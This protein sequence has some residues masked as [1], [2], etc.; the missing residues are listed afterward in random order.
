VAP[1]KV[2][3]LGAGFIADIHMESYSRFVPDAQVTA[4]YSRT[5]ERA[6]H[7]A[8]QWKIPQVFTDLDRLFAEADCEVVD[9]CL[10][11]FLHHKATLGAAYSGRHVDEMIAVCREHNRKLMY[12]EELCFA[13]KYERIR[14][15]AKEGAVGDIYMLKQLEKHSGPHSDWFWDVNQSGGGVLMDMGC[16]AFGWFRWMLNN[17]PAKSVW[18]TMDTVRHKARTKGEDNTV[19]VVEFE[20]GVIG[21]AEDGWAKPGGMD[22]RIEVYGTK[23]VSFADLFRGN[24]SSTYSEEGYGYA[25]EKAGSTTGWTY[26]IFEEAFNQGYPHELHHFIQC[27]RENKTPLVTGED[28]RAVLEMIYAAYAS[29]KSGAKVA[30]PFHPKVARPIDLWKG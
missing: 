27:V 18:A 30:L 8:K 14:L 17:R 28:G 29:A 25:A 19:C 12:A 4:V 21:L 3:I 15:L 13:P 22:D 9:I 10:P 23:G 20:G 5:P 1:T 2:A 24:S 26:T 11:N 6:Q 7:F 16:H